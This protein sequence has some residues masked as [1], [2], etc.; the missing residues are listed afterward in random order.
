M[1]MLGKSRGVPEP[2]LIK[3]TGCGRVAVLR[4]GAFF[5]NQPW[6]FK[7]KMRAPGLR[8]GCG[9][10]GGG[11]LRSAGAAARKKVKIQRGELENVRKI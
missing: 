2:A 7:G 5:N 3:R 1:G 9:A 10:A 11:F 6:V 4:A 8:S